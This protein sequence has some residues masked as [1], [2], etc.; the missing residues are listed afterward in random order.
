[1]F[2]AWKGYKKLTEVV[3]YGVGVG[4]QECGRRGQGWEPEFSMYTF[5]YSFD[6]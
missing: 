3:A 6:F 4:W 2:K 5:V 1:M